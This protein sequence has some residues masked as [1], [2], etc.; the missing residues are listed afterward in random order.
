MESL[1][2]HSMKIFL[3]SRAHVI[4]AIFVIPIGIFLFYSEVEALDPT[5]FAVVQRANCSASGGMSFD[6]NIGN[7]GAS[8][9]T[10]EEYAKDREYCKEQCSARSLAFEF[11]QSFSG[12]CCCKNLVSTCPAGKTCVP[13]AFGKFESSRSIPALIGN[14]LR[15]LI[16]IIGTIALIIF[17]YG[18]FL[19]MTAFGEEEK[20]KKGWDT[21]VWGGFGLGSIFGSYVF[22]S[23]ILGALLGPGGSNPSSEPRRFDYAQSVRDSL[24]I[25]APTCDDKGGKCIPELG[26]VI[27]E[28]GETG[29]CDRTYEASC[30]GDNICC[31][32]IRWEEESAT[33]TPSA[34]A[35]TPFCRYGGVG[36][37]L[38]GTPTDQP[39]PPGYSRVNEPP[40]AVPPP[41]PTTGAPPAD[42]TPPPASNPPGETANKDKQSPHVGLF[43]SSIKDIKEFPN[44]KL[45]PIKKNEKTISQVDAAYG[46]M[47][48]DI[49]SHSKTDLPLAFKDKKL[50]EQLHVI[51]G[52]MVGLEAILISEGSEST[53]T[54]V[55]FVAENNID[56]LG[57]YLGEDEKGEGQGVVLKIPETITMSD[58]NDYISP[59]M[60][61]NIIH[62]QTYVG[63]YIFPPAVNYD[64]PFTLLNEFSA[65]LAGDKFAV[66]SYKRGIY[67]KDGL[68]AKGDSMGMGFKHVASVEFILL[69]L[70]T[71]AAI[72]D[73]EQ[74]YLTTEPQFK[75]IFKYYAQES[76]ILYRMKDE[77]IP[78][79][80]KKY[81]EE[82]ADKLFTALRENN[83]PK[84]E[85]L[86]EVARELF[87]V[88]PHSNWTKEWLGF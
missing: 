23:F 79:V 29:I 82:N 16:G 53:K 4:F 63:Q 10:N 22:V 33:P 67:S 30:P 3:K 80:G 42:G 21:M 68:S 52:E 6:F 48:I 84:T 24:G 59:E 88:S 57:L 45:T 60:K 69:N 70:A 17:L 56:S 34:E 61:E 49:L 51:N 54:Q 2:V 12:V 78:E 25:T 1:E 75:E 85:R 83:D 7:F 20:V 41:P 38:V 66:E 72:M 50:H 40:A 32:E 19:W 46:P 11:V 55:T 26:L 15:G 9:R 62:Y 18:G 27:N 43:S 77:D 76:V 65:Y 87:N 31:A 28:S 74:S 14:V 39:C 36:G 64:Q 86:R 73:N 8:G 71:A 13:N 5:E 44:I 35:P 58:V 37:T 81:R 47:F